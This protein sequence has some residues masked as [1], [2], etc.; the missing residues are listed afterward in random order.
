MHKY[1]KREEV[2]LYMKKLLSVITAMAMIFCFMPPVRSFAAD[3][4]SAVRYTV[5]VD[6]SVSKSTAALIA[7]KIDSTLNNWDNN[8]YYVEGNV[9]ISDRIEVKG[10]AQLILTDGCSFKAKKGIHLKEGNSLTIYGQ[11]NS[12]GTLTAEYSEI[13]D[14]VIGGNDGENAGDIEIHGGKIIVPQC[15]ENLEWAAILNPNGAAIGGGYEAN[16]GNVTVFHGTV[17]IQCQGMWSA[18][19]GGGYRGNGGTV[20]IYGG[21]ITANN[22]IGGGD[23]GTNGDLYI[24]GG[25]TRSIMQ[26]SNSSGGGSLTVKDGEFY[27]ENSYLSPDTAAIS[28]DK[29][30]VSGGKLTVVGNAYGIKAPNVTI[31]GGELNAQGSKGALSSE[32]VFAPDYKP[33]A[34][35]GEYYYQRYHDDPSAYGKNIFMLK[36]AVTIP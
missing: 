31:S 23:G 6:N 19:I 11:T 35:S 2:K 20:K 15:D 24:Y 1:E 36:R 26:D 30:E 33:S 8:I 17:D 18:G 3:T 7:E 9:E 32:P 25:K 5:N 4:V 29:V 34:F 10:N 27:A 22:G 16:G 21:D 28:A 14:A 12:T 13:N